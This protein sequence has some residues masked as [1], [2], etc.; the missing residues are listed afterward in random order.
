ML[1]NPKVIVFDEPTTGLDPQNVV[2]IQQMILSMEGV[3]RIVIT[4]NQDTEFL[5][6]FDQVMEF[7]RVA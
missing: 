2:Q 5:A 7:T 6:D 3:T 1:H 4:H